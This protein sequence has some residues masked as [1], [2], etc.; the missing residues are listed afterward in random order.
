MT[1]R[2]AVQLTTH[3]A[4][5]V[6]G[7]ALVTASRDHKDHLFKSIATG[8]A[9]M[10]EFWAK[11]LVRIERAIHLVYGIAGPFPGDPEVQS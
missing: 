4:F 1:E 6:V 10:A 9:V 7:S 5:S 2:I 11:E 8:Q 3:Q